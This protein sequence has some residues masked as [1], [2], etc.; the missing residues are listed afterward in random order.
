M[1]FTQVLFLTSPSG[2][3]IDVILHDKETHCLLKEDYG[4]FIY[5]TL[6]PHDTRIEI[7]TIAADSE[8]GWTDL[9]DVTRTA[10]IIDERLSEAFS[11]LFLIGHGYYSPKH[12]VPF[13]AV[14]F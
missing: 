7:R 11:E 10:P 9:V 5:R 3:V 2:R 8:T 1:K 4:T 6:L 13:P 14:T 12:P